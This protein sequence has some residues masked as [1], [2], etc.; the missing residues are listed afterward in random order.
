M[1]LKEKEQLKKYIFWAIIAGLIITAALIIKSFIIP[2]LSAYILAYLVR[3]I[4]TKLDKKM[5]SP[6]AATICIVLIIL[7]LIIPLG[8]VLGETIRQG[9]ATLNDK[10]IG[11][12]FTSLT[13]HPLLQQLNLNAESLRANSIVFLVTQLGK[14]LSSIPTAIIS[15]VISLFGIYYILIH[16]D[17]L[18]KTLKNY[19][20][21]KNK[22]QTATE[23]DKT[24]KAIVYGTLLI[25]LIEFLI[26]ALGFYLSGVQAFILLAAL[27]FFFAFLPGLGPLIV[28]G[29]LALIYII[30]ENYPAAIGIIITGL[31]VSIGVETIFRGK[32]LGSRSNINPLIMLIGIIGGISLFGIFGFII[33]PLILAYTLKILESSVNR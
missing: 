11:V 16:W 2:L 32:Y 6:L 3:P 26:T 8:L 27:V 5:P 19:I 13:S 23:I 24:T 1:D 15:L 25:A 18:A 22:E 31:V 4:F 12:L 10:D 9:T 21:F 14:V 28:W 7:V 17:H 33:G 30:N 29:P 20:P